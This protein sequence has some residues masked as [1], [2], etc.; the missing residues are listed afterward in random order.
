MNR[1]D[2]V[3]WSW[4]GYDHVGE[5]IGYGNKLSSDGEM[6]SG[7]K[8]GWNTGDRTP[9]PSINSGVVTLEKTPARSTRTRSPV[10]DE[11]L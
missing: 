10:T 11:K 3:G 5:R 8:F 9:S 4:V 6:G 1:G 2:I 7:T